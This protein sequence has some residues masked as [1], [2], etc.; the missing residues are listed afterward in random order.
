MFQNIKITIKYP[1]VIVTLALLA[2]AITGTVAYYSTSY[3]LQLAAEE[4]LNALLLAR[5]TALAGHFET[6]REDLRVQSQNPLVIR[7]LGEFSE[8]WHQ[9]DQEQGD[10]Q[11]QRFQ[12]LYIDKNPFPQGEKQKLDRAADA[13]DYSSLHEKYHPTFRKLL[14]ER[15]YYDLFLF[16]RDGDLL[17]T[18]MKERDFASNL[19]YG[20]W[21]NTSLGKAFLAAQKSDPASPQVFYDFAPYEPS[22][23]AP[24]GFIASALY[25]AKGRFIGVLA[26]QLPIDR[27]NTVMQ[28][29]AGM[30]KS[31]EIYI[32]GSDFLRRSDSRL[33]SQPKILQEKIDSISV[34]EALAGNSGVTNRIKA[35]DQEVYSAYDFFEFMGIRWAIIAEIDQGEILAPVKRMKQNIL[36]D[37]AVLGVLITL[38]GLY[39]SRNLARPILELTAAMTRFSERDFSSLPSFSGRGDEIGGMEQALEIF[40]ENTL[41]RQAADERLIEQSLLLKVVIENVVHGLALFDADHRLLLWNSRYCDVTGLDR[42]QVFRGQSF[43]ELAKVFAPGGAQD[44][45][46]RDGDAGALK[47]LENLVN[48]EQTTSEL[49]VRDGRICEEIASKIPDGGFV[50]AYTDVTEHRTYQSQIVKQRDDL[51]LLNQQKNRFFSII[52]HDL[53]NPFNALLGY[54]QYLEAEIGGMQQEEVIEAVRSLNK[55]GLQA[56]ELLENLLKWSRVQMNQIDC[57]P[58]IF[59]PVKLEEKVMRDLSEVTKVKGI[60]IIRRESPH[61]V[62]GDSKMTETILRNLLG[63]AIKFTPGGGEIILETRRKKREVHISVQDNGVGIDDKVIGTLFNLENNHSTA[64]TAGEAGTG[65]GLLICKEFAEKQNGKLLVKSKVGTGSIFTLVLPAGGKDLELH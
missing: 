25:D 30:G 6:I 2:S 10:L 26:F 15:G 27:L 56:F 28:V 54:T 48:N 35:A 16:D 14:E 13:S 63:N 55:A 19:I 34:R 32:V 37:L 12:A 9:K 8:A 43:L 18:V 52:A 3:E 53:K 31:G 29:S 47:R 62:F 38:V 7:A 1:L 65:L 36:V 58:E 46:G 21:R 24:A 51:V 42:S 4:K 61:S 49:T 40:K 50:V 44:Q 57:N 45:D 20:P 5:K 64:G 23:G 17:Y 33:S 39:I 11:Q 41:A 59:S 22:H 60:R